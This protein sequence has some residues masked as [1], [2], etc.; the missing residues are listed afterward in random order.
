[1]RHRAGR[2]DGSLVGGPGTAPV[3]F[4]DILRDG[5]VVEIRPISSGDA[6]AL[7]AFHARLSPDT[8]YLRWFNVHPALSEEEVRRFTTVDGSA[9]LAVVAVEAGLLRG[10]ARA[11]RDVDADRAEVAIV[12]EDAFQHRGLGTVLLERLA[13]AAW[14]VGIERFEAETLPVNHGMV[15]V[16]RSLGFPTTCR[17]EDGNVRVRFPIEPTPGYR[18]T[19][20]ERHR[21]ALAAKRSGET[22]GRAMWHHEHPTQPPAP[23]S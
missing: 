11:D 9:R 17:F 23:R 6:R 8:V 20:A 16:F 14:E 22:A 3:S 15:N 4:C 2:V 10:V 18:R 1:M 7:A 5:T 21:T 19:R 12:V 13:D